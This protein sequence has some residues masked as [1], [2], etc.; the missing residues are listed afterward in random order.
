MRTQEA[1]NAT[2]QKVVW[3]WLILSVDMVNT[4]INEEDVSHHVALSYRTYTHEHLTLEESKSLNLDLAEV[5]NTI[6]TRYCVYFFENNLK[7]YVVEA[8]KS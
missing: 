7:K 1:I 3:D 4:A 5:T 8:V 6:F 2:F